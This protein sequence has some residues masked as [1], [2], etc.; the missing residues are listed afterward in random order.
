M[1]PDDT[2]EAAWARVEA[3]LRR[4]TP[5]ER[6]QRAVSL[7]VLAHSLALAQIR[8]QHPEE[9]ERRHRLRLAARYLEPSL[10]EKAFGWKNDRA[11]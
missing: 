4:M 7:T 1:R 9:D 11:G 8:Q 10:M 3:G 2:S 6:V 5:G